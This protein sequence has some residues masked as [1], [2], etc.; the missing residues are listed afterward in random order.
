MKKTFAN[1]LSKNCREFWHLYRKSGAE[2]NE[3]MTCWKKQ[4]SVEVI[5]AENYTVELETSQTVEF[6]KFGQFSS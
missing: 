6:R 1:E 3:E 5:I 4:T 2:E